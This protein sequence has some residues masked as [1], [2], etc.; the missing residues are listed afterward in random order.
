[1]WG[2]RARRTRRGEGGA[3]AVEFALVV[4]F[5]LLILFGIISYGFMLSVRQGM[6]QAAAEGARAA[7]V[8]LVDGDKKDAALAAIDDA[9]SYG[10]SCNGTSLL[11][12]G[13]VVGTCTVS[14][15]VACDDDATC[16]TVSLTY[17]YRDHPIVPTLPGL[18]SAMPATLSYTTTA[19]VS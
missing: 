12:N 6:S 9:L 7:A 2:G 16:V 8:T 14:D 4:P 17:D 15:P 3:A 5:L 1:M 11:R 13:E 19:R 10:V 18:S